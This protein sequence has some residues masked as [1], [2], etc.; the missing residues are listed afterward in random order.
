M[1]YTYNGRIM[2][3]TKAICEQVE[4]EDITNEEGCFKRFE[5]IAIEKYGENA[6]AFIEDMHLSVSWN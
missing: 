4:N 2:E 1:T 6:D 5:E 3:E